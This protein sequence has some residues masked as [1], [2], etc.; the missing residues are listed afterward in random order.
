MEAPPASPA[1][2]AT[3]E[4]YV[5]GGAAIVAALVGL[6][7]GVSALSAESDFKSAP[8]VHLLDR[9][10]QTAFAADVC[11]GVALTLAVTSVTLFFKKPSSK[12]RHTPTTV[13]VRF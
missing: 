10:T 6:G 12:K 8:S 3:T 1:P 11:F 2:R 7:L 4:V 9:G 13:G 5:T